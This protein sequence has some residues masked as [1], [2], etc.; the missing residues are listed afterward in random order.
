MLRQDIST[1]L[2]L[3]NVVALVWSWQTLRVGHDCGLDWKRKYE[4]REKYLYY[5]TLLS[6]WT[7][8]CTKY[9]TRDKK[10]FAGLGYDGLYPTPLKSQLLYLF[11]GTFKFERCFI[12]SVLFK[13]YCFYSF[14]YFSM[15][16]INLQPLFL[17]YSSKYIF[18]WDKYSL[19][20]FIL[21]R[22][23]KTKSKNDVT[24][25]VK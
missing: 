18:I 21:T 9:R 1:L 23:V 10:H 24:K 13:V 3:E 17:S 8:L 16:T 14:W 25:A 20:Y 12:Y 5:V 19:F 2:K 6:F 22:Y 15:Y 7:P 4:R 11:L